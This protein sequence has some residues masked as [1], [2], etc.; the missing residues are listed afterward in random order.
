M[1]EKI[2]FPTDD[3]EITSLLSIQKKINFNSLLHDI[4]KIKMDNR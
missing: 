3:S 2:L 4:R 1:K